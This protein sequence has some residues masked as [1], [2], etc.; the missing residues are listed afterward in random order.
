MRKRLWALE[1]CI[2]RRFCSYYY[3]FFLFLFFREVG[4]II[5]YYFI[6]A[7]AQ[8]GQ[9]FGGVLG[10]GLLIFVFVIIGVFL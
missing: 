8:G 6:F 9:S 1:Y 5:F 2:L 10:S 7:R 4:G 3:Y